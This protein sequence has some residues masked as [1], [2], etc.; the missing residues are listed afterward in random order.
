M[1]ARPGRRYVPNGSIGDASRSRDHRS[2]L[3]AAL[4]ASAQLNLRVSQFRT[5][6]AEQA[7]SGQSKLEEQLGVRG[8]VEVDPVRQTLSQRFR[9]VRPVHTA[10]DPEGVS[11]RDNGHERLVSKTTGDDVLHVGHSGTEPAKLWPAV[12]LTLDAGSG[13]IRQVPPIATIL[14]ALICPSGRPFAILVPDK[15]AQPFDL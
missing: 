12:S 3:S 5:E 7:V 6:R 14:T 4:S 10:D 13:L 15:T 11:L 8:V 1:W 2:G 9:I